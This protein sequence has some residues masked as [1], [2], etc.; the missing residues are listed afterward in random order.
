MEKVLFGSN[1]I[2]AP[3]FFFCHFKQRGE[4]QVFTVKVCT[5]LIEVKLNTFS[6]FLLALSTLS[7]Y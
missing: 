7:L 4:N 1:K 3:F 2:F 6:F 5:V